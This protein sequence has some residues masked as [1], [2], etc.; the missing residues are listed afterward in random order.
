V[1]SFDE[2]LKYQVALT[3]IPGVGSVLAKNLVSYCGSIENIFR[4]KKYQLE[5]IPGIGPDR[6]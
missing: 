4:R 2:V 1:N 6:A 3:L 5:K